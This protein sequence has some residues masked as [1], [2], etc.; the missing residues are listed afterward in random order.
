V[1]AGKLLTFALRKMRVVRREEK[2]RQ[3]LENIAV[4]GTKGRVEVVST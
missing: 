4:W 2:E 1:K 3:V